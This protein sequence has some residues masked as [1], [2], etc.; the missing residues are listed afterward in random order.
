MQNVHRYLLYI[1]LVFLCF[2]A[3]DVWKALWFTDPVTGRE[4]FGLG[5][6]TVVLAVNV[7]LLGGYAFGCHSLRHLLG[8]F[9]DQISKAPVCQKTYACA[10]C[11]NRRHMLWAWMSLCSV[12]F[13]DVYVRLCA[14][15]IWTD[16]RIF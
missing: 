5:V 11:L 7:V 14:M 6:G 10:S 2:L 16:V 3:H 4:T 9:H 1:G 13:S 15:G 8:G 12:M